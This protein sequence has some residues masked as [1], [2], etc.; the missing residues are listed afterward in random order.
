ML[1]QRQIKI[2]II[3]DDEDDYFIISGY[4]NEIDGTKFITE[5]CSNY[6]S[7]VKEI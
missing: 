6:S 1:T 7:A 3:E 5:W 2:L 4:L